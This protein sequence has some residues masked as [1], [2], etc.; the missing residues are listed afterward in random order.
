MMYVLEQVAPHLAGCG[1]SSQ[2]SYNV[3]NGTATFLLQAGSQLLGRLAGKRLFGFRSNFQSGSFMDP[4]S[5]GVRVGTDGS[6]S[7]QINVDDLITLTTLADQTQAPPTLPVSPPDAPMPT[8]FSD[9]FSSYTVGSEASLWAQASG[10]FEVV[11][12]ADG[13]M[14]LSQAAVGPPVK[15][16]RKDVLPVTQLGD[17]AWGDTNLS[18]RL[19]LLP[20][21]KN[22]A[23]AGVHVKIGGTDGS[24]IWVAVSAE[25][26]WWL[27]AGQA[28]QIAAAANAGKDSL[29]HGVITPTPK[30]SA[31]GVVWT[32]VTLSV[33][34]HTALLHLNG[35]SCVDNLAIKAAGGGGGN[36]AL[37]SL[38]YAPAFY[39]D[40]VVSALRNAGPS[41][42]PAPRPGPGPAPLPSPS[43]CELFE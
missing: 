3:S 25:G 29:A 31:D 34:G 30:P 38:L 12:S 20:S 9:N 18:I 37:G 2:G 13:Q 5:G 42:P 1:F 36:V 22:A 35:K 15:W 41:P 14:V 19:G 23:F 28:S 24:G 40:F 33:E 11:A 7:L 32:N 4:I 26:K 16:L 17:Q 39:D 6:F 10:S 8:H 43:K 27:T 21:S